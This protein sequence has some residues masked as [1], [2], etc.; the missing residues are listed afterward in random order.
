MTDNHKYYVLFIYVSDL[1]NIT[2]A[3]A[4]EI[5][6]FQSKIIEEKKECEKKESQT[7]ADQ[8]KCESELKAINSSLKGIQRL[9]E[10]GHNAFRRKID[11]LNENIENVAVLF[12]VE[13]AQFTES[14]GTLRE[15]KERL[16]AGNFLN[17]FFKYIHYIFVQIEM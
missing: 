8:M 6:E 17:K 16:Q 11:Q 1:G 14:I 2:F 3:I 4:R 10:T 13:K 12:K 15:Y 7:R 9:L 5:S